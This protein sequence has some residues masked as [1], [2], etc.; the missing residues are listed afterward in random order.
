MKKTV[1]IILGA[2]V[3]VLAAVIWQV[4]ANLDSIVAGA[5]EDV[6]TRTLKT[7]V[8][9]SGVSIDLKAGKAGIAG[10][11]IAN[12]EGY[13]N[14]N[15]FEME[16]IDIDLDL[17]SISKDVLVIQAVRI[18]N[19]RINFEGNEKGGSNM[20]T[21]LDNMNSAS[22]GAKQGAEGEEVR[23]IIDQFEFTGGEVNAT[24]ALKPGEELDYKLPAIRMS[25]IGQAEG[26][27]TA[28]VVTRQVMGKLVSAVIKEAA[29]SGINKLIE[30]KTKGLLDKL[31]GDG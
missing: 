15:L 13:S 6:G 7:E 18:A 25:G 10:M 19:P 4:V 21:L 26:G 23:M 17:A 31:K 29:K 12:P 8:T 11:T 14:A 28:D 16:G 30:E 1:L 3:L 24:S 27:V 20:Q 2:A 9:V 5:I 22:P